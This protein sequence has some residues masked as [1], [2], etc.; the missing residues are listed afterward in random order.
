[1]KIYLDDA[2]FVCKKSRL[3]YGKCLQSNKTIRLLF[4]VDILNLIPVYTSLARTWNL[5]GPTHFIEVL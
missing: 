2:L 4:L 3:I 5:E 1:M